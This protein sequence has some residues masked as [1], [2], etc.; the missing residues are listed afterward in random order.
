MEYLRA[1]L[2]YVEQLFGKYPTA[3]SIVIAL[4]GAI[5]AATVWGIKRLKSKRPEG[6]EETPAAPLPAVGKLS[7]VRVWNVPFPRNPFFTG[8]EDVLA[9][10][11]AAFA[12]QG[13]AAISQAVAGMGGIGKT[14]TAVEYAYRFGHE[15]AAVLWTAAD[16]DE[17]IVSGFVQIARLLDLP[18]AG[19]TDSR[20]AVGAVMQWLADN[21]HWLLVFDNADNPDLLKG[22]ICPAFQ[23]NILITSRT[24]HFD[25]LNIAAPTKLEVLPLD[26]ALAFLL[27]RAECKN[28]S[29]AQINAAKAV[30]ERL[31]YFPLALE[32]AGAFVLARRCSFVDYLAEYEKKGMALFDEQEPVAGDYGKTVRTTWAMNFTQVEEKSPAAAELLRVCAFLAPEPIPYRLILEGAEHFGPAV[33]AALGEEPTNLI[34]S[35]LLDS[36]ADYSLVDINPEV[37]TFTLHRLVQDAVR[38][39]LVKEKEREFAEQALNGVIAAFPAE[40]NIMDWPWF[41]ALLPHALACNEHIGSLDI[42]TEAAGLLLNQAGF[43]AHQRA[44]YVLAEPLFQRSLSIREKVLGPEHPS[45]ATSLN[46]LAGLYR[47]TGRLS[48]AEPLYARAVV[49]DTKVYG[50]DHPDVATDLNNLA[51]LYYATGRLSKA[52][53]LYERALSIREKVHGPEHPDTAQSLNNLAAIYCATDRL[54]EA[55]LLYK[56]V[57]AIFE[58][59]LGSEHPFTATSLN[60]LAELYRAIGRFSEAEL[61]CRRSLSINEKVLGLEHPDT[62]ETCYNLGVFLLERNRPDEARPYLER[63]AAVKAKHPYV[64]YTVP[65]LGE[66]GAG[67]A[68]DEPT[69]PG[70]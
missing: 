59:A 11:R 47:T 64:G 13:M 46:N 15:Y 31:G 66:G 18:E 60:N 10:I 65:D 21:S 67:A 34:V 8:R 5:V 50:P 39:G 9:G 70:T 63:A 29:E 2:E 55:E 45:T 22:Y 6:R 25:I 68:P 61:L 38:H 32:Q 14:Q 42:L 69:N 3:V 4:L 58:K 1:V 19:C 23:G 26:D 20:E 51:G 28:P 52:E 27:R 57:V 12:T 37:H 24:D 43:Y 48:K 44:R 54:A 41:E 36:L 35:N 30:A 62:G 7:S 40:Y 17:D 33:Q 16:K 56:R 53:P 49:I